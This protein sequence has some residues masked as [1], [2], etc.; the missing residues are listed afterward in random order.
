MRKLFIKCSV[1]DMVCFSPVRFHVY[2]TFR[3]L[4]FNS[5][6]QRRANARKVIFSSNL[7]SEKHTILTLVDQ[8]YIQFIRQR[9]KNIF[10]QK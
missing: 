10:F 8:T 9:R 7:A 1:I 4:A 5:L 2:L 6:L 3:L